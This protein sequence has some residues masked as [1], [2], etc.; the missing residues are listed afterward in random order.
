MIVRLGEGVFDFPVHCHMLRH[1]AGYK[2]INDNHSLRA[3]QSYM[4]HSSIAST[5]R[6]TE[7]SST[8]FRDFWRS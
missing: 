2:L 6:Y 3:I 4:G 1:S 5:V 7:L 8:A